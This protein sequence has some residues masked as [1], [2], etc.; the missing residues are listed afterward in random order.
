MTT[1]VMAVLVEGTTPGAVPP[2]ALDERCSNYLSLTTT[3]ILNTTV[4]AKFPSP[5]SLFR[6]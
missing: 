5:I 4:V 2:W 1:Y 3:L 6:T